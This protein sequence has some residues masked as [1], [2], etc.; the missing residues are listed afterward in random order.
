MRF[1]PDKWKNGDCALN[2]I[3][4]RVSS[5]KFCF[6]LQI[7]GIKIEIHVSVERSGLYLNSILLY[8]FNKTLYY[9]VSVFKAR[10]A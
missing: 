7:E 8:E 3:G 5:K 2:V 10:R 6:D 4:A 9:Q 1:L